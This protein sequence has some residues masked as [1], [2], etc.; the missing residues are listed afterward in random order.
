L[1]HNI[2]STATDL[3][4]YRFAL[5]FTAA[6]P[7]SA[8]Q[9]SVANTTSHAALA[10]TLA[11]ESIVLLKNEDGAL[12]LGNAAS[13]PRGVAVIGLDAITGGGGSGQVH[14]PY[15]VSTHDGLEAAI[16]GLNVTY[17]NGNNIS[18]GQEPHFFAI[19]C[20]SR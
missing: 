20:C 11:R 3:Y 16:P 5:N 18:K 2:D 12:P 9:S 15:V 19:H 14:P 13:L 7:A 10:R 6:P 17:Y 8:N 1:T 4:L